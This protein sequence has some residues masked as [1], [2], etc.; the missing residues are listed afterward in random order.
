MSAAELIWFVADLIVIV[1]V[2]PPLDE[3]LRFNPSVHYSW[4]LS[5]MLPDHRLP[6]L[7]LVLIVRW[8]RVMLPDLSVAVRRT[9][10]ILLFSYGCS[11]FCA[12]EVS[13]FPKSQSHETTPPPPRKPESVD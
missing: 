7:G 9:V 11:G 6:R 12:V 4:F 13:E 10:H 3:W 1:P 8:L 2:I 5:V